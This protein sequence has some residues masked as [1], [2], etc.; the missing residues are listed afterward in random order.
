MWGCGFQPSRKVFSQWEAEGLCCIPWKGRPGGT[1]GRLCRAEGSKTE[2]AVLSWFKRSGSGHVLLLCSAWAVC[3]RAWPHPSLSA[4]V[5]CF[6]PLWQYKHNQV[7]ILFYFSFCLKKLTQ[8]SVM[9]WQPTLQFIWPDFYYINIRLCSKPAS[10]C[11][12]QQKLH[13]DP[14]IANGRGA[15]SYWELLI[16][17]QVVGVWVRF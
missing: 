16:E 5:Q 9:T 8:V 7:L 4:L 11:T 2:A 1:V 17:K 10:H 14:E 3:Q 6:G 12:Q 15:E 13:P